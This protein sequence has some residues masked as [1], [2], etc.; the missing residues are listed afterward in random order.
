MFC[1]TVPWQDLRTAGDALVKSDPSSSFVD[2]LR[3][4]LDGLHEETRVVPGVRGVG[5]GLLSSLP[6]DGCPTR[7]PVL[8]QFCGGAHF[9]GDFAGRS[10]ETRVV[11]GV[12]GAGCGLL[13]SLPEDRGPTRRP[14]LGQF[15]G[16]AHSSVSAGPSMLNSGTG[17][18]ASGTA[19]PARRRAGRE[20]GAPV[21][22]PEMPPQVRG[23]ACRGPRWP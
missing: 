21:S 4:R 18:R 6:E 10:T 7:R 17:P 3:V 8:G 19:R 2:F 22:A 16:G 11:P 9:C 5:C 1:E 12:R 20:A 13:S 15:C 23:R 14:G